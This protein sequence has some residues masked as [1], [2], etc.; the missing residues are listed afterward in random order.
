MTVIWE[1]KLGIIRPYKVILLA[2]YKTLTVWWWQ[3][4]LRLYT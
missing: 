1:I 2:G 4:L 3:K